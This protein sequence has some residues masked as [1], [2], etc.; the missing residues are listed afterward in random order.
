MSGLAFIWQT[1]PK[2]LVQ[3]FCALVHGQVG[4]W[5]RGVLLIRCRILAFPTRFRGGMFKISFLVWLRGLC[6][7]LRISCFV[8]FAATGA[9]E[10]MSDLSIV[11]SMCECHLRWIMFL[12]FLFFLLG[13]SLGTGL[14][15][16]ILCLCAIKISEGP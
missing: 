13:L 6:A 15:P 4:L 14:E 2:Y 1:K 10:G 11:S 9:G 3:S 8:V 12:F 7:G 5:L 16:Y